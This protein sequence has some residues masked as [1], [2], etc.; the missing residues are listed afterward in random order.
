MSFSFDKAKF[1]RCSCTEGRY[2]GIKVVFI[3]SDVNPLCDEHL[4]A[5]N[6]YFLPKTLDTDL[7]KRHKMVTWEPDWPDI[8]VSFICSSKMCSFLFHWGYLASFRLSTLTSGLA[9]PD[10]CHICQTCPLSREC[11]WRMSSDQP[12]L[13]GCSNLP[14]TL[15]LSFH[16]MHHT[17][18][19]ISLYHI[20]LFQNIFLV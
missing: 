10:R 4:V 6:E 3:R 7:T 8:H 18:I 9:S 14:P 20:F 19:S 12:F 11:S 2:V 1:S 16:Y 17:F 15:I 13:A 5:I